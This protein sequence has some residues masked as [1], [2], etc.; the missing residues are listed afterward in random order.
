ME[1]DTN[2]AVYGDS[3]LGS[4]DGAEAGASSNQL[5]S[6]R[7]SVAGPS[8]SSARAS[9]SNTHAGPSDNGAQAPGGSEDTDEISKSTTTPPHSKVDYQVGSFVLV[10]NNERPGS[11]ESSFWVAK[12]VQVIKDG[13]GSSYASKL[14][15]HWYDRKKPRNGPV[16]QYQMKYYPLYE[17]SNK[18]RRKTTTSKAPSRQQLTKPSHDTIHTDTVLVSF[19][20]LNN[21]HTIPVQTLKRLSQ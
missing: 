5:D 10:K 18:K 1:D 6:R 12:V 15:V 17:A 11:L 4:G 7:G 21:T 2:A 16:D 3:D 9:V 8:S 20:K 13:T 19:E 14:V